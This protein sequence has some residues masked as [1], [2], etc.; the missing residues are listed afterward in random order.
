MGTSD[1]LERRLAEKRRSAA[2]VNRVAACTQPTLANPFAA[3]SAHSAP[4]EWSHAVAA[5]AATS[6]PAGRSSVGGG[7]PL[8]VGGLPEGWTTVTADDGYSVY[9]WNQIT[10]ST[11]WEVP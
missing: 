10:G 3:Q 8:T 9:Y 4:E 2:E 5:T 6:P 1:F 7:G 11:S